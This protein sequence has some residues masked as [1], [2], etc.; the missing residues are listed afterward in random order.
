MKTLYLDCGMGAAGD[1][2]TA[3]LLELLPDPDEFVRNLN[4]LGI[5]G[6]LYTK[7]PAEKCGITGTH[8]SVTVHGV[9]EGPKMHEHHHSHEHTHEH[10]DE[11]SHEHTHEG[12]DGHVHVHDHGDGHTHSHNS[13]S[14]IEHIVRDHLDLPEKVR[15]DVMGVYKLIAEAESHVHGVPVTDIHFHEVGTMDAVADI[16]AVCLLMNEL[17]SDQVIASPVHVGSGHVKCAHGIL[18]VP[19]PATAYILQGIPSYGGEIKGELCT[20]TGAALLKHFVTRF[21]NMPVMKTTAIGYGMG[22]KD[23]PMAN[24]IRAMLGETEDKTDTVISLSCSVDDMTAEAIAFAME[25]LFESGALDVFTIPV[26]MKKN[27]PGTLIRI[28]CRQQD[29][30]NIVRTVFKH[31]TTIGIRR[32]AED[33]YVLERKI[34]TLETPYGTIRR[35]ISSG[36]GVQ[37]IKYE[38]D[39]LSRIADEQKISIEEVRRLIENGVQNHG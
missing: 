14:G 6:V 22:K 2:L 27:R 21:G 38:Y 19:A 31:T 25:K 23:F 9:E 36:Y 1:M 5:P 33:R 24:C 30:G 35:K 3:A 28:L 11:H 29:E 12:Q 18:P 13:L 32:A 10:H 20:P 15:E 17:S 39:D 7:E 4:S 8:L 37:R 26:G 16:T 34:E